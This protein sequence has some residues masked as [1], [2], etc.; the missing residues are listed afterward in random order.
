MFSTCKTYDNHFESFSS[1][2]LAVSLSDN[3]I[4]VYELNNTS[5][6]KVCRLSGHKK[7]LTEVVFCP[8]EDHLIYSTGYD[9]VIKLWDTRSSGSCVQEYKGEI[10]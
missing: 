4:E 2:K 6:N 3:S 7:E 10:L 1:L 8:I 5:L 9:G